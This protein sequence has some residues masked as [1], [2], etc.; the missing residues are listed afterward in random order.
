MTKNEKRQIEVIEPLIS[1]FR[2]RGDAKLDGQET[3]ALYM[4]NISSTKDVKINRIVHQMIVP[5]I[6]GYPNENNYFFI[7]MGREFLEGGD[8]VEPLNIDDDRRAEV[9]A[10]E[11]N[12]ILSEEGD[13]IDR[14]YTQAVGERNVWDDELILKPQETLSLSYQSEQG[15]GLIITRVSFGN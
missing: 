6:T 10:F 4:K 9:T 13:E 5:R 14:W 12:P 15:G 1:R 3:V 2:V 7:S 8:L 11:N